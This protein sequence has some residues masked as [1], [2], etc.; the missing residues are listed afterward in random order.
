MYG[1][2][3]LQ[4]NIIYYMRYLLRVDPLRQLP[5]TDEQYFL[6]KWG[7]F[8]K[9]DARGYM[10]GL[11]CAIHLLLLFFSADDMIQ[12]FEKIRVLISSNGLVHWEPG[13]VFVTTCDIDIIY[14]PF[15]SQVRTR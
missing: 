15:D 4:Y 8:Q 2:G 11:C 12:E 13:G 3:W 6:C 14:F 10:C 7:L 9:R 1:S 5:C